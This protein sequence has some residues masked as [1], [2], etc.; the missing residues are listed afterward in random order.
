MRNGDFSKLHDG[1]EVFVPDVRIET[2]KPEYVL[3][4]A[5]GHTTFVVEGIDGKIIGWMLPMVIGYDSVMAWM[6]AKRFVFRC[7]C[8]ACANLRIRENLP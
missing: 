7:T 6:K 3:H 2:D 4:P 1:S 5:H 8:G